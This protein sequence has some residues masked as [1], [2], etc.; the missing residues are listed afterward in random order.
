MTGRARS[1]GAL[2]THAGFALVELT[3]V[4]AL[5]TLAAIWAIQSEVARVR[6][7][8]ATAAGVWLLEIRNGVQQML[9]AHFDDLT[10][11]QSPGDAQGQ[12]LFQDPLR[13]T[14]AELKHAGHLPMS[15]PER[16]ALGFGADIALVVSPGC[17][18]ETCRLDALVMAERAMQVDGR[19][20]W[21]TTASAIMAMQGWGATVTR[22]DPGRFR[23]AN[24][25][26]PNPLRSDLPP[27][28]V[29][30]LAAWAGLDRASTRNYLRVG[31]DRD[32][33]FKGNVTVAGKVDGQA[34]SSRGRIDAQG[35]VSA[36]ELLAQDGMRVLAQVQPGASCHENG[37]VS[38]TASG[39]IV[40][41]VG[42]TWQTPTDGFGGA[43]GR[44]TVHG[45]AVIGGEWMR[46]PRTG[47]CSCPAGYK[48]VPIAQGAAVE[49]QDGY[50]RGYV[51]MR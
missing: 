22:R 41:C 35:R 5:V 36:G 7:A 48:A 19:E 18:K 25:G 1:P 33:Q 37:V 45:C 26:L 29:G 23:G 24:V 13:P 39:Q 44:N 20:D 17:P 47:D 32:P 3:L 42:G 10:R 51:C 34:L 27:R 6:D 14:L 40:A 12:R 15:F 43:F 8:A 30:T 9:G 11:R 21:S 4:L 38:R 2:R 16:S 28:P 49:S 46:N 50:T 31:D